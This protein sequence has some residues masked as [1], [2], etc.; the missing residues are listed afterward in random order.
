MDFKKATDTLFDRVDHA[1]LAKALS[2]SIPLIRQARL[3]DTAAAHRSPPQGWERA[4]VRLAEDRAE[5]LTWLAE[6]V[7][8]GL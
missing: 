7:K 2:V 5:R 6:R 4:V 3:N 8:R 1:D